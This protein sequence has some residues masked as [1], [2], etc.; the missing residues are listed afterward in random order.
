[1]KFNT[2]LTISAPSGSTS[3]TIT[4]D[5][6][7]SLFEGASLDIDPS[8]QTIV[9]RAEIKKDIQELLGHK[10]SKT[11]E[12]YTHVSNRD[13]GKIK[14]PLDF[15]LNPEVKENERRSKNNII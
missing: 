13:S 6:L 4:L 3:F 12:I 1:V 11:T 14:S 9:D 10:S 7:A 5:R 15:I 2:P 8:L